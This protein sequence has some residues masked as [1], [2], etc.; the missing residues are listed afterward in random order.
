M[1]SIIRV[2]QIQTQNGTPVA[3]FDA[4]GGVSFSGGI[5]LPTFTNSNRPSGVNGLMIYNSETESVEVFLVDQWITMAK[6][7]GAAEF[8]ITPQ[9]GSPTTYDATQQ[10]VVISDWGY[11]TLTASSDISIF[12]KMWGA[13]GGGS[14]SSSPTR[15]SAGGYSEGQLDLPA[16]SHTI[17]IGRGGE[18]GGYSNVTGTAA[19][20]YPDGGNS[21][22]PYNGY[23]T[24]GG[25]GGST[26]IGAGTIAFGSE[27]TSSNVYYMIAGGGGAGADY[28]SY[29]TTGTERGE[30]GGADGGDGG[31]YY[32]A[33]TAN[34]PGKGGSQTS[35]GAG[36][37]GGRQGGGDAGGKY[38]GGNAGG[39]GGGGGYYG[40]GG[41]TGYYTQGGGGSGYV[42]HPYVSNAVTTRGGTGESLQYYESHAASRPTTT[43][44]YGGTTSG[45]REG[46]RGGNG[47]IIISAVV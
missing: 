29:A 11:Y 13:G 31:W 33:D 19:G 47:A 14:S 12:V 43:T 25:G 39:G 15:G 41:G 45:G 44:G 7:K 30:G 23:A 17:I 37:S 38:L 3:Q 6:A 24:G 2:D 4:G 28:G 27:N 40:G 34:G 35:G 22:I 46:Q 26:R 9:G 18:G 21:D 5:T 32:P 16:G 42:G 1:T 10:D 36:G 8:T 20:G